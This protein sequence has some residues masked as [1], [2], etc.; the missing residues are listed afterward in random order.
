[1]SPTAPPF[2]ARG[3]A[4]TDAQALQHASVDPGLL[5]TKRLAR[6]HGALELKAALLALLLPAGSRRAERAFVLE[7]AEVRAA[8]ELHAQSRNLSRAARL[9]WLECLAARM[10]LHPLPV[11]QA[12]LQSARRLMGARG[13]WEPRD[14]LLWMALRRGLGERP[15]V[16]LRPAGDPCATPWLP[17]E[18]SAIAC[19]T[20]FLA[21][22]V[23]VDASRHRPDGTDDLDWMKAVLAAWRL[24]AVDSPDG[25]GLV[26]AVGVLQTLPILHRPLLTR[27]WVDA[28]VVCGPRGTLDD[29]TADA[30]RISCRLLDSPL[31]PALA[32]HYHG[33]E[34][35]AE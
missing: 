11:R 27:A 23:S 12:L 25:E 17:A 26:H 29:A 30:L 1:M 22:I 10:S 13:R 24:A 5:A 7:T 15:V 14:R 6:V 2:G 18:G 4:P 9:P 20:A 34:V 31:P 21:R 35:P 8:A 33:A 19:Y 32:R 28:A 3:R 16:R